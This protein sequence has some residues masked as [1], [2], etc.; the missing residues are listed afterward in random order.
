MINVQVAYALPKKQKIINIQI[1]KGS[2]I[3]EAIDKSGILNYFNI[4][5]DD[6][7]VGIYS[8]I[9]PLDFILSDED[10]IEIY[11]PLKKK[12]KKK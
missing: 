2:T 3:Q 6:K 5:L 8:Q 4:S 11:R 7:T 9:K 1:K 12:D 10:R